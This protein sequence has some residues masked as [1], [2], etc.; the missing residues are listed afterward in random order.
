MKFLR[1]K[2]VFS[3]FVKIVCVVII[4]SSLVCPIE[5]NA[6]THQS[7]VVRVGVYDN[8]PKIYR[9]DDGVIKGF[10]ADVVNDIAEEENWKVEYVFG[11]WSEGLDRLEKGEIDIMVDVAV[12][13]DR[14]EVYDFSNETV[15]VNWA[16]IYTR[17]DIEVNSIFDL[18]GKNIAVMQ[19]GIHFIGPLGIKNLL[20]GFNINAN[21][22]D[23]EVYA[24]VFE[25]LNNRE[26]DAG[27]VN[28]IFG[29]SNADKYN[30]IRTGIVFNPV[31]LRFAFAKNSNKNSV[32]IPA[33][34]AQIKRMKDDRESAYYKSMDSYFPGTSMEIEIFP[35]WM[36]QVLIVGG[37]LL[38]CALI[39]G[40]MMKHY[41]KILERKV[42]EKTKD[43]LESNN[44][45]QAMIDSIP[46]GM[47]II[48]SKGEIL[49]LNKKLRDSFERDVT[50]EKCWE[51][52]G[53]N[54]KQPCNCL[55]RNG[56]NIGR[57]EEGEVSSCMIDKILRIT[58]TGMKYKDE[59]AMM[60]VFQDVTAQRESEEKNIRLDKLKSRFINTLS[61]ITR[62][63]LTGIAWTLESL[64]SGD[65]GKL[66]EEQAALI[67][68][69]LVN[70]KK[71]VAV[72]SN[73]NVALDIER[74]MMKLELLE[75]M[76]DD[77]T[78]S[79]IQQFNPMCELKE[80]KCRVNVSRSDIKEVRI[81]P[82]KIRRVLD[83][84]IFNAITYSSKEGVV[85]VDFLRKN[86]V[87]RVAIRDVGVGI[88]NKEQGDIFGLFFRASNAYESYPDGAGIGLYIAK[89]I[90][91][92]HGGKI[93]FESTEGKGSTFWFELPVE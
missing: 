62:T 49:F 91:E 80:I 23:T 56:I 43:L 68:Q 28:R 31:E 58:Y 21:F 93:G 52:Y 45:N 22:I 67:R 72:I 87:I 51:V 44:F 61:H 54:K 33:I 70:E 81:D 42:R 24:D 37:L 65:L 88:P 6:Q 39:Y 30:V 46:F 26:V 75:T 17:P 50:G 60:E 13:E 57:V 15:L 82:E 1:I 7:E 83:I 77:L 40:L 36:K 86:G 90:V 59:Y 73:M 85:D 84:L 3:V 14:K 12:S 78:R 8:A 25:K 18:E 76:L 19:S 41:Q 55:L 10:W 74:G 89:A 34:D 53:K 79:V 9:D 2:K 16:E 48:N 69:A 64:L 29:I 92:K 47:H 20:D 71:I 4:F 38:F 27:V 35:I 11:T 66:K 5:S 63:P 32:L